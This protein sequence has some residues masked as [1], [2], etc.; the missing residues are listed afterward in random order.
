MTMPKS[1]SKKQPPPGLGHYSREGVL[2]RKEDNV[3]LLRFVRKELAR[4]GKL[5]WDP[6]DYLTP[7]EY[8]EACRIILRNSAEVTARFAA[9]WSQYRP[10][11]VEEA[12]HAA[13]KGDLKPMQ[14]LNPGIVEHIGASK[15]KQGYPRNRKLPNKHKVP[16]ELAALAR[17]IKAI[18]RNHFTP[19]ERKA[20]WSAEQ[21]AIMILF[22]TE[23]EPPEWDEWIDP[24][25][26]LVEH[27]VEKRKRR[28]STGNTK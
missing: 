15:G 22:D 9:T 28:L 8:R 18:L 10:D 21:M 20:W 14:K 7:E 19:T 2:A 27:G 1:A 5:S 24:L 17:D 26:R 16:P 4:L 3:T 12:K 25:T 11:P 13:D 6:F 23:Q